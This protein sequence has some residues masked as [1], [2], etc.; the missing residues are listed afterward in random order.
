V[1]A[2]AWQRRRQGRYRSSRK[3]CRCGCVVGR[4]KLGDVGWLGRY[5]F[6]CRLHGDVPEPMDRH[7]PGERT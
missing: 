7:Q 3:D 5:R 4:N 2:R 6:Y 1:S